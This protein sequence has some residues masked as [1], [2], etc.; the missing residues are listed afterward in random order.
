MENENF[1][2]NRELTYEEKAKRR[3][4]AAEKLQESLKKKVEQEKKQVDEKSERTKDKQTKRKLPWLKVTQKDESPEKA[5]EDNDEPTPPTPEI[6]EALSLEERKR[7]YLKE[8]VDQEAIALE[9]KIQSSPPGSEQSMQA[10]AELEVVQALALKAEDPTVEVDPAIDEEFDRRMASITDE[11]LVAFEST[12]ETGI[13]N[14]TETQPDETEKNSDKPSV[15]NPTKKQLSPTTPIPNSANPSSTATP[16]RSTSLPTAAPLPSPSGQ[17]R[18]TP[19]PTALPYVNKEPAPAGVGGS[20][21]NTAPDR[22]SVPNYNVAPSLSNM[23][24]PINERSN[25]G[26]PVLAGAVLGYAI[27]RRGGRKRTEAKLQPEIDTARREVQSTAQEAAD[28]RRHFE[29]RQAELKS[30]IA[31]RRQEVVSQ[32][33]VEVASAPPKAPAEY[34]NRPVTAEQLQ[35]PNIIMPPSLETAQI[36]KRQIEAQKSVSIDKQPIKKF[37][38]MSTPDILRAAESL[39]VDGVSIR[40]LY[41]TNQIDRPGLI[42]IVRESMQ[43]GDVGTALKNVRLGRERQLGRAQEFKHGDGTSSGASDDTTVTQPQSQQEK[44]ATQAAA[45]AMQS[46]RAAQET[47]QPI[48]PVDHSQDVNIEPLNTTPQKES[49][50]EKQSPTAKHSFPIVP[51]ILFISGIALIVLWLINNL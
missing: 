5:R 2:F 37:E 28:T 36:P 11:E 31:A 33:P 10:Q 23:D 26:G 14:E 17:T 27:G 38:Q 25:I 22:P 18:F 24:H 47:A 39:H 19:T 8:K 15:K 9:E 44:T 43:G 16:S 50:Q 7:A 20:S 48:S 4:D 6:K 46:E 1:K 40:R 51:L 21:Y 29:A 35:K 41:E 32:P 3:K 45:L 42:R 49:V 34:F 12:N 30:A 13:P